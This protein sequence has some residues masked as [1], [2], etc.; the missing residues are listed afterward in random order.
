MA[1]RLRS[2]PRRRRLPLAPAERARRGRGER[3]RP[4]H[5][6]ERLTP[7]ER[8]VVE[9]VA[10]D[11]GKKDIAAKLFASLAT[12]KTH[13]VHVYRKLDIGSRAELAARASRRLG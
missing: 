8:R 2:I 10:E 7:A 9:L 11:L 12:V 1:G 5:G 6:W 4:T 3:G 13:L